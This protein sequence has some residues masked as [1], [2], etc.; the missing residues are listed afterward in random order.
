M[1]DVFNAIT[2]QIVVSTTAATLAKPCLIIGHSMEPT[3]VDLQDL[4]IK[5]GYS[6]PDLFL[7]RMRLK[8]LALEHSNSNGACRIG[9][10]WFA[11]SLIARRV[12]SPVPLSN[13]GIQSL[14][15]RTLS[16]QGDHPAY[17]GMAFW[18]NYTITATDLLTI[19]ATMEG[20]DDV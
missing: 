4:T 6:T 7:P 13:N 16:W 5:Q 18:T 2:H 1:T 19:T 20:S 17:Y 12:L 8:S 14:V 15:S 10:R 3:W 11:G 9:L